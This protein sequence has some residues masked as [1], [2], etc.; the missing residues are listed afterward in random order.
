VPKR[1]AYAGTDIAELWTIGPD[2]TVKYRCNERLLAL[3]YLYCP[4]R[5]TREV[6]ASRE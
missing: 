3:G 6:P 2:G 1:L 4:Q 5:F